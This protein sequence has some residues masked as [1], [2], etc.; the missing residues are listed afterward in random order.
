M[1]GFKSKDSSQVPEP[2]VIACPHCHQEI[3]LITHARAAFVCCRSCLKMFETRGSSLTVLTRFKPHEKVEP[4]IPIGSKGRFNDVLYAVVGYGRFKEFNYA[5]YWQEYVL[6]NPVHGYALLS[7]YEGHWNF[8]RFISDYSHGQAYRGAFEYQGDQYHL[9]NQYRS[10][11]LYAEGEFFWDI[12]DVNCSYTEYVAPPYIITR[13][14]GGRELTWMQGAYTEPKAIQAAFGLNTPMPLQSGVGAAEPFSSS[15]SFSF[16]KKATLAAVCLLIMFQVFFS[17]SSTE[18]LLSGRSYDLPEAAI[19]NTLASQAGPTITLGETWLGSSNLLF[20]LRAPVNNNWLSLGVTL[21][22]TQT[23]QE[24]DFEMGVEYYSGYEG[25]E[26]WS[27]G[28]QSTEEIISALPA[29]TYQVMLQPYRENGSSVNTF[30][31]TVVEDVPLWSN[32]WVTL[33]L[34]ILFPA[35]HWLREY[36]FEKRR[37]MNSDYTPYE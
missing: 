24:Y 15:I 3:A 37:W 30:A 19:T 12:R 31:L 4:V 7:V 25:G 26:N 28:S 16:L 5:Y 13:V 9:Y 23:H 6:F 35:I 27:E 20:R 2:A 14:H 34:V 1:I 33:G 21:V 10:E 8:F 17:K 18:K 32:F 29:G 22:N 11:A 36:S